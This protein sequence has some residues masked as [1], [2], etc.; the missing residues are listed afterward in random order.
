MYA[1]SWF[2]SYFL[3]VDAIALNEYSGLDIVRDQSYGA[4]RGNG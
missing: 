2:G 4:E 3:S 1:S